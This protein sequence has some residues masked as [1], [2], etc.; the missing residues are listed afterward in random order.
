MGSCR[1]TTK[2]AVSELRWTHIYTDGSCW[3]NPGPGGWA[4]LIR[5]PDGD[6]RTGTGR[7]SGTSNNRMELAAVIFALESLPLALAVHLT[8][9]SMYVLRSIARAHNGGRF[10]AN[11]D[12][13]QRLASA[14]QGYRVRV[15]HVRGHTGHVDNER[16]DKLAEQARKSK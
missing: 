8:T 1:A 5:D 3:P 7:V 12:L 9:D 6:E 2:Q 4:Y 14:L 16:V 13:G 11:A 10:K 15:R